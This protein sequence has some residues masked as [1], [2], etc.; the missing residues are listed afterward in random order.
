M[1][2]P[3]EILQALTDGKITEGHTRPILMLCD[4]PEEQKTLFQEIMLKKITVREAESI[5]RRI[6]YDKVRK[7]EYLLDPAI[8][9][10]E[11]KLTEQLGTRVKIERRDVGGKV[12]I[13]FISND[14]L[15][16]ILDLLNKQKE[17]AAV[18]PEVE[19]SAIEDAVMERE[20]VP[21]DDTNIGVETQEEADLYNI[22]NFSI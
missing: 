1:A 2:L 11:Q 6:A 13:D 12:T 17:A 20:I 22:K 9:D 18:A 7:K 10:M 15:H 5:A 19:Q 8:A 21:E 14:D 4:R 16:L 3:E